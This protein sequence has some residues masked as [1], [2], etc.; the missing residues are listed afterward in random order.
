MFLF[1]FALLKRFGIEPWRQSV[2]RAGEII[3]VIFVFIFLFF[4]VFVFVFVFVIIFVSVFAGLQF[5]SQE[6]LFDEEETVIE[7]FDREYLSPL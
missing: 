3:F 2:S 5:I 4:F 1:V 6:E 7:I